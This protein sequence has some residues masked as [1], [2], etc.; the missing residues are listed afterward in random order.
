MFEELCGVCCGRG[1]LCF[2]AEPVANAVFVVGRSSPGECQ[3]SDLLCEGRAAWETGKF[4]FTLLR[5]Q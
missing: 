4:H 5:V 2:K 3:T 1:G